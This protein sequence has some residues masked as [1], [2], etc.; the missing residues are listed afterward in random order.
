M[1]QLTTRF[2]LYF[3]GIFVLILIYGALFQPE[4]LHREGV[5]RAAFQ[6]FIASFA[7][8]GSGYVIERQLKK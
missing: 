6:A 3:L 1:K 2:F 5:V 7:W 8:V 4:E